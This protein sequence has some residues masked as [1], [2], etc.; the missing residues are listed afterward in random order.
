MGKGAYG[1][2][3]TRLNNEKV[4]IKIYEKRRLDEPNKL[5]NL[6][7]EINILAKLNHPVIARLVEAI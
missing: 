3:K 2:V 4:A 6:E 7:R 5:R 1:V